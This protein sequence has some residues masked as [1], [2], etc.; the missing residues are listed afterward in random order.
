M[1]LDLRLAIPVVCCWVVLAG[2]I[3]LSEGQKQT[4]LILCGVLLAVTV[5]VG[6]SCCRR[7]PVLA[8]TCGVIAS[9]CL[10]LC[11]QLPLHVDIE[12]WAQEANQDTASAEWA[13]DL[14]QQLL[15]ASRNFPSVGGQL[16]PGLAVGD[17]SAVSASLNE[18]M[19]TVS[20]THITAVSGANCIIVTAGVSILA[21]LC[22]AGRRLRILC[23]LAAL[24]FFVVLVTPQPSVLRASVMAAV[25]LISMYIGRPG[26]GIPILFCAVLLILLWN[27]W[28][29]VEY[30]FI[31]SGLAVCGLLI[32]SKPLADSMSRWM[33]RSLAE[34]MSI[35]LAAQLMCQPV[36][37]MLTPTV[38]VFGLLANIVA[39][40]AAPV[41]TVCGLCACLLL[42]FFPFLANSSCGVR[43][44]L[45]N[46]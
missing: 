11:I 9:G 43:G 44:C 3:I 30:G 13:M 5:V 35:P 10:S 7:A 14:R 31:L 27:P 46:G 8:L 17:T 6:I 26:S 45:L 34:V 42:P 12:P 23:G 2:L 4:L 19:K 32:F 37:I 39:A 29:A 16:V 28:W 40:P 21:G 36:L 18:A 25:V 24:V 33:P 1:K 22:G 38:P 15:Q 20:L 41:A